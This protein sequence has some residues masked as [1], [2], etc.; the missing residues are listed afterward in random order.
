MNWISNRYNAM[1]LA[2]VVGVLA[3]FAGPFGN[4][5]AASAPEP[6]RVAFDPANFVDPT[7]STNPYHPLRP[8]MQWTRA[9]TTEV[10]A[11]KVPHQVITTMTDVVRMIDGVPAVAMLD[12]S[13]DSGEI[14][15]V[16][17]DYM[18]LDKA[19][20]VW[21]MGGYT[22][23]FE[24]GLYTN[25]NGVYLGSKNGGV[26]GIL[27]PGVVKADTPR[28]FIGT[29]GP[30]ESP[31]VAEPVS[32]GLDTSVA[33]GD[34]HNVIAVREGGIGAIDNEIKYYAPGVGVILN[35]PKLKSLHQDSFQLTNLIDLTPK[36]LTEASQVVLDQEE[37]ARTVAPEVYASAPKAER[38][39]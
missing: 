17:F 34:F 12:Q 31:S 39:R 19:G 26:P 29:P 38:V 5:V 22:E 24:G 7:T 28:W 18:A 27:M 15:Q 11:R 3:G 20:N 13:Y 37:H 1:A 35:D 33:F 25:V 10:G 6:T 9:G 2:I 36:G 32:V 16:G 8:G 14:S 4:V 21:L 30:D 23:D